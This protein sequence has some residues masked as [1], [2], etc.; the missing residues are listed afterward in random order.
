MQSICVHHM[1]KRHLASGIVLVGPPWQVYI[2]MLGP[3]C[4]YCHVYVLFQLCNKRSRFPANQ[5][6]VL[7]D[8]NNWCMSREMEG[9]LHCS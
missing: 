6:A 7:N 5:L 2:K 9:L 3:S 1:L 8:V 4:P